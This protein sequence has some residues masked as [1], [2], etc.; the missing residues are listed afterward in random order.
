MLERAEKMI[1][2]QI[3]RYD[4]DMVLDSLVTGRCDKCKEIF[5]AHEAGWNGEDGTTH[6][7]EVDAGGG[8]V[9]WEECGRV[10]RI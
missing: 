1:C 4:G 6:L 3:K 7:V 2:G 5:M 10:W 9:D 8:N